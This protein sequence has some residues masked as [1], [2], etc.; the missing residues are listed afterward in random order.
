MFSD[1]SP[2]DGDQVLDLGEDTLVLCVVGLPGAGKTTVANALASAT[3]TIALSPG[4]ALRAL[5]RTDGALAN[6][7]NAG[8]LGPE[9][10]VGKLVDEFV[11][12]SRIAILDGYP[13]HRAQAHKILSFDKRKLIVSLELDSQLA[14]VRSRQRDPRGDESSIESRIARDAVGLGEVL[15]V[16]DQ[17]VA[18]YDGRRAVGAIVEEILRCVETRPTAASSP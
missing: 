14:A 2:L 12:T 15:Q 18:A 11:H 13:R 16:L 1:R 8:A 6:A 10:I 7:L 3:G 4:Q 9:H 5:A 17:Y